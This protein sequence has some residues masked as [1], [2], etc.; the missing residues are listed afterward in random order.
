V[1]PVDAGELGLPT[2]AVLKLELLQHTGSFKPRGAFNRIVAAQEATSPC[3]QK[4]L[5]RNAPP[6]AFV[7]IWMTLVLILTWDKALAL[8]AS[9]RALSKR[10]RANETTIGPQLPTSLPSAL[11][12]VAFNYNPASGLEDCLQHTTADVVA[13]VKALVA[14]PVAGIAD[15]RSGAPLTAAE[16]ARCLW[17]GERALETPR[18]PSGVGVLG[19]WSPTTPLHEGLRALFT[20]HSRRGA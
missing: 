17:A 18:A 7:Q 2:A 20:E 15:V 4:R 3:R 16:V 13:A 11:C 6:R 19:G 10:R 12:I 5:S 9:L 8:R 1:L 14:A